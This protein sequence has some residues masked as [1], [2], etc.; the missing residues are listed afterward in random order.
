M[1]PLAL[2]ILALTAAGCFSFAKTADDCR[3]TADRNAT[4]AVGRAAEAKII[5]RAGR[6]TVR[7]RP[8][9]NEVR[10]RGKACAS[11]QDVLDDIKLVAEVRGGEVF[12]EAKLPEVGSWSSDARA[13][14]DLEIELPQS[15][16]LDV[17]DGSGSIE[18]RS[19]AALRLKDGSGSVDIEAIAGDVF[20]QDGSGSITIDGAG[21]DVEIQDGS[22]SITVT[23]VAGS[24]GVRDGSGG[25]SVSDVGRNVEVEDGAGGMEISRVVGD[26]TVTRDGSGSISVDHVGGNFTVERDGSGGVHHEDVGGRVSVSD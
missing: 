19:A 8:D 1:R 15:L 16:M 4:I 26:V 21:G 2:S 7:G 24:V 11:D 22:G 23:D 13:L 20:V 17:E 3:F 5:A 14:L 25:L 6:L 12:I 10:V 9:L 18:I